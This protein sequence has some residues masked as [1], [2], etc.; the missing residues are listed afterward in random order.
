MELLTIGCTRGAVLRLTRS[1][2]PCDTTPWRSRFVITSRRTLPEASS[3]RFS[4]NELSSMRA[5]M[6]RPHGSHEASRL[7][8]EVEG[9]SLS[10]SL[11]SKRCIAEVTPS[12]CIIRSFRIFPHRSPVADPHL[13]VLDYSGRTSS[14]GLSFSHVERFLFHAGVK[15]GD[16]IAI[17]VEQLRRDLFVGAEHAF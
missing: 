16:V 7:V 11:G 15:L 13:G 5:Y 12:P 10:R 1:F 6:R 14:S 9:L 17:A 8:E 3:T 4:F 2:E